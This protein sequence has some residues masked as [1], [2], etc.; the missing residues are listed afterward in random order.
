M[1][2]WRSNNGRENDNDILISVIDEKYEKIV[3]YNKYIKIFL[4][5][6]N[7]LVFEGIQNLNFLKEEFR[8]KHC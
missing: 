5:V 2:H 1:N 4:L 8:S 3:I 7:K 6:P